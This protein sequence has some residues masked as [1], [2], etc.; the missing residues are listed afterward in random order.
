MRDTPPTPRDV[1][2]F[3]FG[4][5]DDEAKCID[6]NRGRWFGGGDAVNDAIRARFAG[7]VQQAL[8]GGLTDWQATP[9][10]NLAYVLLLDQFT[11]NL[12]GG[13]PAYFAG[14]EK[15]LAAA[16]AGLDRGDA[17]QLGRP[18]VAFLLMPL[19]HA[20]DRGLQTRCVA[21]FEA[22]TA[23]AEGPLKAHCENFTQYAR[24]HRDIVKRFG[25]FPHRNALL[26]RETTPEEAEFLTQ[27]G[28]SYF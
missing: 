26:G 7:A 6:Q 25:R 4:D 13:S 11:R 1:L 8:D 28:S 22:L 10:G 18:Q 5:T 20:E 9:E 2:T 15:A 14:D 23:S 21:A 12:N 19:M 24:G 27:P 17:A 16:L 3:W